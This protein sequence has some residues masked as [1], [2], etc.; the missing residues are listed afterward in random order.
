MKCE[1]CNTELMEVFPTS[2]DQIPHTFQYIDAL[3][4]ILV[5][6]YGTYFDDFQAYG[7]DDNI[8]LIICKECADT[9]VKANPWLNRLFDRE[10]NVHATE[11]SKEVN[12]RHELKQYLRLVLPNE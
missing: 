7:M 9:L 11:F 8:N 5:S 12:R 1:A 3:H 2:K 4:I 6:N 10:Q